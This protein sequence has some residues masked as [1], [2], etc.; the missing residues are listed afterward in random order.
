MLTV[1]HGEDYIAS[2]RV[3]TVSTFWVVPRT[4]LST[5]WGILLRIVSTFWGVIHLRAGHAPSRETEVL[6]EAVRTRVDIRAIEMQAVGVR[7]IV[8]S[9]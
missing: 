7:R 4:Y 8:G 2:T 9:R 1:K 3:L 5:K 6:I